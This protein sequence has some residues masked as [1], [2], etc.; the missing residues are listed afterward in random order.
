MNQLTI[1]TLPATGDMETWQRMN[2]R[3]NEPGIADK[4]QDER[5]FQEIIAYGMDWF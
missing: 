2:I 4:Y 5:Y 1:R 3:K